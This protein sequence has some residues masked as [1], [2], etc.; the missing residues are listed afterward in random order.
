MEQSR[1]LGQQWDC[2]NWLCTA[3]GIAV[4]V[5]AAGY[6]IDGP[7]SGSQQ[8]NNAVALP[9]GEAACCCVSAYV[10]PVGLLV[11][12]VVQTWP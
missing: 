9:P 5:A 10:R 12:A 1:G 3:L 11:H 6:R 2:T 4:S 7:D 8:S